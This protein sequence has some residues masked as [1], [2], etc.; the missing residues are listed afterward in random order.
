MKK[1]LLFYIISV[2]LMTFCLAQ[3][4]ESNENNAI[5]EEEL[6]DYRKTI[7]TYYEER[8]IDVS[9]REIE[10]YVDQY[11]ESVVN[12]KKSKYDGADY[13]SSLKTSLIVCTIIYG[14][15]FLLLFSRYTFLNDVFGYDRGGIFSIFNG[16]FDRWL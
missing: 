6:D 3:P 11:K 7:T 8:G 10:E 16:F 14:F 9:K 13:K 2:I 5:S 12:E 4:K 1:L 15:L